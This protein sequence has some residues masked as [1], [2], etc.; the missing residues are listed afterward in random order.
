MLLLQCVM[1]DLRRPHGVQ[2]LQ[3]G[4]RQRHRDAEVP[5]FNELRTSLAEG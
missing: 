2:S 3:L 4:L 1:A 5:Y